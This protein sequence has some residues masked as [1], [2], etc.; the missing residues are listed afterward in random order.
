MNC[1]RCG[2]HLD[3]IRVLSTHFRLVHNMTETNAYEC[4][5]EG[6]CRTYCLSLRAFLRHVKQHIRN[7]NDLASSVDSSNISTSAPHSETD[8]YNSIES[9]LSSNNNSAFEENLVDSTRHSRCSMEQSGLK[10]ALNLHAQ[11][12][13]SRVSVFEI[14]NNVMQF[15][16]NPIVSSVKNFFSENSSFLV[17]DFDQRLIQV[18][19][20]EMISNPFRF[21]G[22]EYDLFNSLRQN[23]Y[24]HDFY[25]FIIN[26]EIAEQYKCGEIRYEEVETTGVLLPLNFQF[27]KTFEKNDQLLQTLKQME[28][29]KTYGESSNC[30]GHFLHGNLWREK[31]RP[32]HEAGKLVIPYFLYIDDSEINNPLGPHA[33]PVT[34][35]YYSF[36]TLDNSEIFL[37]SLIESHD[38]KSY[39]NELCLGNLVREIQNMEEN[40][41]SIRTSEGEKMI[42]FI[43]GLITGDNLGINTVLDFTPSF[44]HTYCCRFCKSPRNS[45]H[46]MCIDDP[47]TSRN[48]TNYE[49]DVRIDDIALT[50][51][52]K[53]SIFNSINSFHVTTNFAVDVMHDIFEGIC[54]YDI[55]HIINY[56]IN[57]NYFTLEIL[58]IRKL[59]FNYGEIEIGNFSPEI[60]QAH[61]NKLEFKM[62]AREMMTFIHFFPLMVGDLVP[63][64]DDV[65]LFFLDL[66]EIIDILLLFEI[67]HA[68]AERLRFLIKRHHENYVRFFNDTLKPKHHLLLHYFQNILQSGPPRFYWSFRFES[69]HKEFKAYARSI[70][71]RKNI[72]VSIAKKYQLKFANYLLQPE[73]STYTV[74]LNHKINSAHT[75]LL[76]RFCNQNNISVNGVCCYSQCKYRSKIYKKGYFITQY[77][78]ETCCENAIIYQIIEIVSFAGEDSLH[79]VCKQMK[80]EIYY[81]HFA[82]YSIDEPDHLDYTVLPIEDLSGPPINLHKTARGLNLIR[83]KQYV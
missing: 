4:T 61:L 22:S 39:G 64:D 46:T 58:N 44:N 65:W 21:C 19:F 71:S 17:D 30:N 42:Y 10:F 33:S 27:R 74:Q 52:K 1:F 31:S 38:Y 51:V 57:M 37:A 34:F 80:I 82:S 5:F 60:T 28:R 6:R 15:I 66:L 73:L 7:R 62:N 59:M 77:L 13:F 36:P 63:A 41:I 68:M 24:I 9:Q 20:T 3:T 83:P 55:G 25:E 70:T 76:Y 67:P 54:H 43:P 11:N 29:I 12:N 50:G 18:S 53:P 47:N 72:C 16:V 23:D 69:K 32:F 8:S 56:L 75:V 78:D 81:K 49:E 45:R 35:I 2:I 14:Q 79:L 48:P 26:K 40:G